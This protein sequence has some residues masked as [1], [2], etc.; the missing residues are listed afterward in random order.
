MLL[1][2]IELGVLVFEETVLV[3]LPAIGLGVP[4]FER[5]VLVTL[6]PEV[7]DVAS[8]LLEDEEDIPREKVCAS[9]LSCDVKSTA[10]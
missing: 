6:V 7:I 1:P 5:T 9:T 10:F 8:V 2:A 3:T 4:V